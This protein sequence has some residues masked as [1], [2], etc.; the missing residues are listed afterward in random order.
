MAP[1]QPGTTLAKRDEAPL[2]VAQELLG[3]F[4]DAAGEGMENV[5]SN[6]I[7][8]P[9]LGIIQ[10]TSP[11]VTDGKAR[12]G[13][14]ANLLTG[15]NFGQRVKFYP[16]MFWSSRIKWAGLDLNAKIECSAK[17]GRNG[18]VKTEA[19]GYGVCANCPHS[20]WQDSEGPLCTEFKNILG[21]A[22]DPLDGTD[23]LSQLQDATPVVFSAKRTA[24]KATNQFL[25]AAA[26]LR[27]NGKRPPLFASSWALSTEKKQNDSGTY[28]LPVFTRLDYVESIEIFNYLRSVYADAKQAQDRY[29]VDQSDYATEGHHAEEEVDNEEPDF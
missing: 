28:F 15:D 23:L 5:S 25:S 16:L 18:T 4:S 24:I 14:I 11:M 21:I 9:R 27:L 22:I 19:F 17:D 1:A 2:A 6:E 26:A 13:D 12:P 10:P 7:I 8:L 29:A 20:Q 3:A